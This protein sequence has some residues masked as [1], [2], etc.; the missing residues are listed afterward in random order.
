MMRVVDL[1][2]KSDD[3]NLWRRSGIG[4]SDASVLVFGKHFGRSVLQLYKEKLGRLR[5]KKINPAMERGNRLE[6]RARQLYEQ[7][8]G[9]RALPLCCVHDTK[10][11]LKASLDGWVGLGPGQGIVVEIKV[12]GIRWDGSSDHY[13]ALEG[14]IPEKYVPQLDHALLVTGAKVAHYVSYNDEFPRGQQFVPLEHQRD[15]ERLR[16]LEEIEDLFWAHVLS[17]NE[18]S[19]W[20]VNSYLSDA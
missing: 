14:E 16:L 19:E 10:D 2:Q 5:G 4:S 12:P 1:E 3:W 11:H 18:P 20:K 7:L 13:T 15:E 6:A 8:T 9:Y 17:Q